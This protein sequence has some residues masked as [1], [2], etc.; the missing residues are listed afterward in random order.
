TAKGNAA[1]NDR[2]PLEVLAGDDGLFLP[3]LALGAVGLV[4]VASNVE[5]RLVVS[6]YEAWNEG[7]TDDAARGMRMLSLMVDTLFCDTSPIPV[8]H[9]LSVAQG[10]G[11]GSVRLPLVEADQR[12]IDSVAAARRA[13]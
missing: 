8:K 7:R 13:L 5:P 2:G 1:A 12:V 6:V 4:S 11:D 3:S 9:W 10:I